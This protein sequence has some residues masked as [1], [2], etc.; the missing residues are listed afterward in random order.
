METNN[1]SAGAVKHSFWFMEF[2]KIV[3][4]RLEGNSWE[5][6]KQ[7]NEEENLFGASTPLRANQIYN[8]LSARVKCL[9]DSF[10]P[11]FETCDLSSQKLFALIATMAN[12]ILFGEFVYEVVREKMIIG[13]NELADSDIRIFFRNKQDQ[14]EKVAG[15]TDA[16]IKRL[17][18]S[19]K[20]FLF[21]AGLT[22]KGKT[23]RKILRPILDPFMERWLLDQNMDYYLKALTGV[24]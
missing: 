10:Y 13:N 14:D 12:D 3:K 18:A 19:Y 7:M 1:Y 4:L 16:T 24:R 2:R 23:I 17:G 22:D 9:D 15:W 20:S 8:T 6:I 11:I 21:E 5:R